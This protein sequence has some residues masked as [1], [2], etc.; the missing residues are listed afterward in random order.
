MACE[1]AKEG[2]QETDHRINEKLF[3]QPAKV[4]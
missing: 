4:I 1:L 2:K 3:N